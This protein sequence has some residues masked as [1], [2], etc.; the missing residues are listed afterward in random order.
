MHFR[1][2]VR[3]GDIVQ[4][5]E[6]CPL[7]V[8]PT[9]KSKTASVDVWVTPHRDASH[10]TEPN[11]RKLGTVK[12]DVCKA[13]RKKWGQ[14]VGK[15]S[16]KDCQIDLFFKFGA[17]DMQVRAVDVTNNREVS[18]TVTF[19]SDAAAGGPVMLPAM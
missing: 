17:A 12:V 7:T 3:V 8:N 1:P 16:S 13:V 14:P 19:S 5:G 15:Q 11:M 18:T 2:L 4:V 10:V 9:S 6:F